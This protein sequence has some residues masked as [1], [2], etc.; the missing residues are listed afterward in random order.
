[1]LLNVTRGS[2]DHQR[3]NDRGFARGA[4]VCAHEPEMTPTSRHGGER[5]EGTVAGAIRAGTLGAGLRT[6]A[7]K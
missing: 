1:M 5:R 3:L 2:L 6:G 4:R 7:H